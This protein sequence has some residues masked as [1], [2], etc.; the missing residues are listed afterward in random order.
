MWTLKLNS[1]EDQEAIG[2]IFD[3][4]QKRLLNFNVIHMLSVTLSAISSINFDLF[5]LLYLEGVL[6][7]M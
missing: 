6:I 1:L 4:L 3:T 7:C 2:G 5:D